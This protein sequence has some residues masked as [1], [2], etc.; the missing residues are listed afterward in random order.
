MSPLFSNRFADALAKTMLFFAGAHLLI[1]AYVG[2]RKDI[3]ALNAFNIIS[4]NSFLPSLGQGAINFTLS[5]FLV[6][7]VYLLIYLYLTRGK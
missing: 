1:L 6:A 3:D 7:A 5:Y 4:L 2:I